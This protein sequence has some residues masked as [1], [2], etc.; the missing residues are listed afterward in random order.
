MGELRIEMIR[1]NKEIAKLEEQ[2][3]VLHQNFSKQIKSDMISVEEGPKSF[4]VR[5]HKEEEE[6]MDPR[7]G[8]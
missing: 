2:R 1:L 5:N 8:S 7:G 3:R 4:A 6:K